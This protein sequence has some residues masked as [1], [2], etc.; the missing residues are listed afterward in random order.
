MVERALID[1]TMKGG[2][3]ARKNNNKHG[4]TYVGLDAVSH[5]IVLHAHD[6]PSDL[7]LP[8]GEA[9]TSAFCAESLQSERE[10]APEK[11]TVCF[12]MCARL[13]P[14]KMR[15]VLRHDVISY[16]HVSTSC[17]SIR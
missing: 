8:P 14:P 12:E 9:A 17:V 16:I 10:V 15:C 3:P 4:A 5:V 2:N 1:W 6:F 13:P 11:T 7:I